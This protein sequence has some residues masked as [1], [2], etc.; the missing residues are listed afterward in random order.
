M[1][2][3]ELNTKLLIKY[4][5]VKTI[6]MSNVILFLSSTCRYSN[7]SF[8]LITGKPSHTKLKSLTPHDKSALMLTVK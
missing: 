5:N 8:T 4:I 1:F 2:N 7:N 3:L 6:A